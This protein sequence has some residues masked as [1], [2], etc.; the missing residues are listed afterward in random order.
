[1]YGRMQ[2]SGITEIIPLRWTSAL[3]L[4][5]LSGVAAIWW[6]LIPSEI[7]SE[8]PRGSPAQ[9]L[10]GYNH[11]GLQW[12]LLFTG[13]ASNIL[14]LRRMEITASLC[15]GWEGDGVWWPL[16]ST[17]HSQSCIPEDTEK[18]PPYQNVQMTPRLWA[19]LSPS[20]GQPSYTPF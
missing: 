8:F 12:H 20:V 9:T 19:C 1:M 4:G 6:L 2:E 7:N 18:L 17:C 13:M 16:G 14:F 15:S 11:W 5:P 10:C 3:C